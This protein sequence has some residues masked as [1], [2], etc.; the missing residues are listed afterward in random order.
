MTEYRW[1]QDYT[2]ISTSGHAYNLWTQNTKL[3]YLGMDEGAILR[4][5]SR[6]QKGTFNL[7]EDAKVIFN[8]DGFLEIDGQVHLFTEN[9]EPMRRAEGMVPSHRESLIHFLDLLEKKV[10]E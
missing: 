5:H 9:L 7:R 2:A 10:K 1:E 4:A 6:N 3:F 8:T